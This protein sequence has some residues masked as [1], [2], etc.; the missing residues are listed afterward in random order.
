MARIVI[1]IPTYDRAHVVRRAIDSVLSQGLD[2]VSCLVVDDGS[3]DETRAV[4]AAYDGD[5]RV[6]VVRRATNGGVTAAK[7]TGL[8]HLP[9]DCEYFGILDSD[10]ALVPGALATLLAGFD[11]GG[12][13][14]QVF[15][16]CEDP[17]TR[18]RTGTTTQSQVITYEQALCGGFE[19]EFWQLVRTRMLG[20]MRFES[21]AAGGESSLW[22]RLMKKAPAYLVPEVVRMYDRSGAD[23]VSRPRF[24]RR[25][26]ERRMWAYRAR[27]DA[28]GE[29]L[30]RLCPKRYADLLLEQA[31]WAAL[32]GLR[33]DAVLAAGRSVLSD[34]A[35]CRLKVVPFVLAPPGLLRRVYERRYSPRARS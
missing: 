24:D 4:L 13:Y 29:D 8:D 28:V 12:E 26:S 23:R 19:G 7:N 6:E 33:K 1:I 27:V 21:R 15:G 3:T 25:S 22:W 18:E 5:P 14:S 16:W 32:A 31:K 35:L 11:S 17:D 2:D 9:G 10:D 34:P 20:G 30:R